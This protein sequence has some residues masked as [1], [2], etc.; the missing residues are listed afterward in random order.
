M[1]DFNFCE[2][3]QNVKSYINKTANVIVKKLHTLIKTV[4]KHDN[5]KTAKIKKGDITCQHIDYV[6]MCC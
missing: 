5:G 3:S 4:C 1:A 6:A 2:D